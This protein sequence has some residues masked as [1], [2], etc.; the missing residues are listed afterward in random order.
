VESVYSVVRTESLN[1]TD[2]L[3]LYRVS[4]M[5]PARHY[6]SV[7]RGI[8]LGSEYGPSTS[9]DMI[10]KV[11]VVMFRVLQAFV[12]MFRVLLCAEMQNYVV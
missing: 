10:F 12:V 7:P 1:K 6:V 8:I 3:R 5:C 2:T 4:I 11:F 9:S